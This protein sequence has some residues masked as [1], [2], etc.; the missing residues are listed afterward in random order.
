MLL[1]FE[2][3]KKTF[4][5]LNRND[6]TLQKKAIRSGFWVGI[7][8]FGINVLTLVRSIVL[9][10]LLMPDVFGLMGICLIVM[11]GIEV[12]TQTGF[13]AALIHRQKSFEEAKDTA[14]T[15]MILRGFI[16][17]F[18][19]FLIAPLV[20][21]YYERN[22]LDLIIK[23]IAI[24]FIFNGFHN[25]NTVGLQK[26]L[27]FKRLT[28]LEHGKAVLSF[29]IVVILAY[30]F[31]NI[32]VLVIGLVTT[33]FIGTILSFVIIPGKPRIR[34]DKKLTKELFGYGKF[35][36]GLSV[37]LFIATGIDKA[38][39]GKLLGMEAL[40]YYVL[41]YT[42]A[43]F[44]ATQVSKLTSKVMFPV[45]SKAQNNLPV[46]QDAYLKVLK[47]VGSI[48]IPL[49]AGIAVL[50]PEII[51]VIYG[52][53]WIPAVGALQV[54]CVYGGF[55]A[56][57]SLNGYLFNGIGKPNIPFYISSLRLLMIILLI[58]PL[59]K[60]FGLVGA[61][62]SIT[63]SMV[64]QFFIGTYF[65]TRIV[66]LSAIKIMKIL[67]V[68]TCYSAIMSLIIFYIKSHILVVDKYSLILLIL[69]G[70]FTYALLNF[71]YISF[72]VKK[73]KTI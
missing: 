46:L 5:F 22:V 14:F 4:N 9:A 36:T 49:A 71:R 67:S 16:L 8:G 11:Q 59:T 37:V 58:Y 39:I 45:Y 34:L 66:G 17:A 52:E 3:I 62:F 24:S 50:A 32:W 30:F 23:I 38:L 28:Y 72:Y 13:G 33:S 42:L 53:K 51:S 47:L 35:I 2:K 31:R 65:F 12:F 48:A 60:K 61:S 69:L 29:I 25:I 6:G 70:M 57:V 19:T 56:I 43:I 64:T 10:R 7:S 41:A 73:L 54:L 18:V 55:R 1:I 26:E 63:V 27:D 20:A 68:I 21:N 40:G 44:P 15:L